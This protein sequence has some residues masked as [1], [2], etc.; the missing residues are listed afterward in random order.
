MSRRTIVAVV[1]LAAALR[2]WGA[3]DLQEQIEDEPIHVATALSLG[4]WGTTTHNDWAHPPLGGLLM[5]GA[6][7]VLGDGP[8]GWRAVN[9]L[10]GTASVLLLMLVGAHLY[11]G[12]RAP[13]LAG[14][15]LALDPFHI[16]LSRTTFLEVPVTFFFLAF[17]LALLEHQR[18]GR[19]ALVG[20]GVAAGLT[21]ATKAYFVVGL[22]LAAA[23]ALWAAVRRSPAKAAV[24]AEVVVTLALTA[25]S[26]YLLC[27]LPILARGYGL[28]ELLQLKA[29]AVRVMRAY[30]PE[31]FLN[32]AWIEAGGRPWEWFVRPFLFGRSL[33]AS[34][35][36]VRYLLENNNLPV[37]IL[38]L[39]ALLATAAL[40]WR[41]R[42]GREALAPALF[43]GSYG[44][45]LALDRPM[46]S[47][48]AAVLLPFAYLVTARAVDLVAARA[49]RPGLV[50]GAF[51]GAVACWG[52]YAYP[53]AAARE[54]PAALYR[55]IEP[56]IRT[57]AVP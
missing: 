30:Q 15:L 56:L 55:P 11:P 5:A 25:A 38:A 22:P 35:G 28:L 54:V 43:A 40:A 19:P 49:R 50:A 31:E 53:L 13:A 47:Y 41:R 10:L 12:S 24:A 23:H 1:A 20:A 37:R 17:L 51:L 8:P 33:P 45:I 16:Y 9:L 36:H 2:G 7:A 32:R 21:M 18:R 52:A 34:G 46:Y 29:D 27:H 3:F 6:I 39:P 48:S 57:V 14:L 4:R 26:A 42:D 44:M